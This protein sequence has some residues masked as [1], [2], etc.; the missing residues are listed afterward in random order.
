MQRCIRWDT[1][2]TG[3]RLELHVKGELSTDVQK[4]ENFNFFK[5]C[6]GIDSYLSM[7]QGQ[8]PGNYS[9]EGRP[10][11]QK[12]ARSKSRCTLF[13]VC[14]LV[15]KYRTLEPLGGPPMSE[16]QTISIRCLRDGTNIQ[17]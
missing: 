6:L 9:N 15:Y 10:D 3:R 12:H 17:N 8:C 13:A 5:A 1:K 14:L 16:N 4:S 7:Y 11:S 2:L